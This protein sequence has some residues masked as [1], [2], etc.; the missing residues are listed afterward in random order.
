[1]KFGTKLQYEYPKEC[2]KECALKPEY[3]YQGCSCTRCPI[4]CCKEPVTEEDKKYMPLVP[5]N[6][7]RNDWAKEWEEFFKTGK[8]PMLKL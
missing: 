2:P 5:A 7:F 6:Q 8:T 3:F 4:V 1:M